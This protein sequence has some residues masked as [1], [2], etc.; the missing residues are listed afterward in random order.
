MIKC[1]VFLDSENIVAKQTAVF[2]TQAGVLFQTNIFR[3]LN[4]LESMESLLL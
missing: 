2:P 4:A 1:R 3:T